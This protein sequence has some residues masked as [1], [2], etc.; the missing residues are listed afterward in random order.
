MTRPGASRDRRRGLA[1]RT[2]LLPAA[3]SD[4]EQRVRSAFRFRRIRP[5]AAHD[6]EDHTMR[7]VRRIG[8]AAG[9]ALGL[10]PGLA[11]AQAAGGP[12]V[13]DRAAIAG[14]GATIA[15]GSFRLSGTFGQPATAQ[16]AAGGYRLY[17]GFWVP[18]GPLDDTIFANGF[19]P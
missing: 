13:I 9:L 12:Y 5:M 7:N 1:G 14:G 16:L 18:A 2:S 4:G 8:L 17:D 6:K 10:A 19:D 3:H 15:G 11:P